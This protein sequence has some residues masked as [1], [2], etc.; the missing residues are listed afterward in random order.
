MMAAMVTVELP[1]FTE[2]RQDKRLSAS[3]EQAESVQ[4]NRDDRLREL[5][6]M[7]ETDYANWQRLGERAHLYASQLLRESSANASAS[8]NAYQSGVTEFTTLMRARIT[9]L[10]VRL[11]ELRI[12]VDRARAQASLLYLAGGEQ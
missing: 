11:D 6:Q 9:D 10:D 12:R 5:K 2:N 1:W 8:L 4:L 3:I 7:L